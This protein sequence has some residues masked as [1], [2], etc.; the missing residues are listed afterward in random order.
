M[1]PLS[2]MFHK[3][4]LML[5]VLISQL[6]YPFSDF[7]SNEFFNLKKNQSNWRFVDF[8]V[9]MGQNTVYYKECLENKG[10]YSWACKPKKASELLHFF[11]DLYN[12][13][14]LSVKMNKGNKKIPKII[15]QIWLGSPLPK[16]YDA[17]VRSWE[18]NHPGWKYVLWT[19]KE[20]EEFELANRK[21][22]HSTSNYGEKSDI[23][24]YEILY[25]FGGVYVDTDLESLMPLDVLHENYE[26]Y[27]G[28]SHLDGGVLCL[29]N[30]IIGSVAGHPILKECI[31]TIKLK[32][33]LKMII[34]ITGPVHFTQSFCDVV[35]KMK[36]TLAYK[37]IIALP[38][39]YFYPFG[40]TK[41]DMRGQEL[42][43]YLKSF[44]ESFTAHYWE[45]SWLKKR[46]NKKV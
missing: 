36:G 35:E 27:T 16:K 4:F 11:R 42:K 26:F 29:A 37:N 34:E 39:T 44:P 28:I 33:H 7:L 6:I 19:D 5:F 3:S 40:I 12:K 9:S 20:I 22:Y 45:G 13:N 10:N 43:S 8:D 31:E 2:F 41:K 24:R 46:A 15:H 21:L 25:R 32:W 18:K 1:K 17:W 38:A 23:A 14:N 30:G